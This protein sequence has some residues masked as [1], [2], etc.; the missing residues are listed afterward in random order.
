MLSSEDA[1]R[2]LVVSY[3][4]LRTREWFI[5]HHIDCGMEFFT[6]KTIPELLEKSLETA[7]LTDKRLGRR[8]LRAGIIRRAGHRLVNVRRCASKR[9]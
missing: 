5:I 8:R 3:K 9:G 1:I 6:N 4:L 7:R 2:S